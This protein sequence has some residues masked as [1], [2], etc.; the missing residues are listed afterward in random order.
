MS[1]LNEVEEAFRV[2]KKYNSK[3]LYILQCTSEY[4][5]PSNNL[6]LDV[7]KIYR[8]KFKNCGFSDHSLG[9]E[10]S[11][12]SIGYGARVLEKHFTLSK[13]LQGP[14]HKASLNPKELKEYV[15]HI[16]KAELMIGNKEKKP[17]KKELEIMPQ[18]RRG[19]V[20]IK[21]IKKTKL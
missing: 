11:L 8:N 12:L 16:R 17:T 10:A 14:D 9:F 20:A 4:P 7:L 18:T 21:N 15:A 19:L 3:K 1:K 13:K 2:I 5:C 6:N